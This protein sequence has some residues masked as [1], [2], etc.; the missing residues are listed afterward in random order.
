MKLLNYTS[1]YFAAL[2]LLVISVWAAIFYYTMLNEIY[3]SIDDGLDNQKQLVIRKALADTALLDKPDFGEGGYKIT[4]ITKAQAATLHDIYSDT[5]MYMENENEYEPVRLLKTSFVAG[6]KY[7]DLQIATSMVEEDDLVNALLYALIGLYLG[8]VLP[9]VLLNNFLLKKVWKPFYILLSQVKNFRVDK[10]LTVAA[11]KT[12]IEEFRLLNEA[13]EKMQ[14]KNVQVFTSQKHFIENAAHELQTPL[15]IAINK[16][17]H[18]TERGEMNETQLALMSSALDNLDRL[19]RLN[20]S[21][22]LLSKIENHQYTEETAVDIKALTQN[23]VEDF[24]EQALYNQQELIV[25][26]EDCTAKMNY[27]LAI[28]L[29]TNLIKNAVVHTPT[30]GR[31]ELSLKNS[32]LHISNSG[33]EPL[34]EAALFSRFNTQHTPSRST[35]L[36]LSIVKAIVDLYGFTVAYSYQHQHII[37]VRFQ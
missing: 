6:E 29:I 34:N 11:Q 21:L 28:I 3:D 36:G 4:P 30:G 22:L 17:E 8:I 15:A 7:Y 12:R 23:V 2:I 32:I 13:I 26:L 33:N 25:Q 18:L 5:L 27:D 10:P 16:L 20:R 37:M 9:V 14:H 24:R 19:T 1:S 31:I 35:G